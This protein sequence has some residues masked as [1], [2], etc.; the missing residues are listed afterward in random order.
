MA[1]VLDNIVTHQNQ[2]EN[3]DFNCI[4]PDEACK[5][6]NKPQ[7]LDI[8]LDKNKQNNMISDLVHGDKERES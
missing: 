7:V 4:T 2:S 6:A 8:N 1:Y 3:E 5:E